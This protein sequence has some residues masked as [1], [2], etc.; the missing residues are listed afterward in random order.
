MSVKTRQ[1]ARILREYLGPMAD[2]WLKHQIDKL[3]GDSRSIGEDVGNEIF[4]GIVTHIEAEGAFLVGRKRAPRL[5]SMLKA[6]PRAQEDSPTLPT[7]ELGG[8]PPS[9]RNCDVCDSEVPAGQPICEAC[10]SLVMGSLVPPPGQGI[11][12]PGMSPS[13][14]N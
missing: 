6:L 4:D 9:A 2:H 12:F 7:Q 8:T 5:I 11:R 13:F 10:G 1:L 3:G 14:M